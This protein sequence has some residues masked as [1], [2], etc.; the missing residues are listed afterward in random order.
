MILLAALGVLMLVVGAV[1]LITELMESWLTRGQS[2]LVDG[3]QAG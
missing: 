2:A 1:L 3:L